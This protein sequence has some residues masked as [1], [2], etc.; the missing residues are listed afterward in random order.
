M[1]VDVVQERRRFRIWGPPGKGHRV[2]H[3]AH[4]RGLDPPKLVLRDAVLEQTGAYTRDGVSWHPI[5]QLIFPLHAHVHVPGRTNVPAPSV[6]PALQERGTLP[7]TG[8]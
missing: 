8:P 6:R 7:A 4:N 5:L 3:L 2:F 1:P